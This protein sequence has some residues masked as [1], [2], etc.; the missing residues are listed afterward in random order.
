[1]NSASRYYANRYQDSVALMKLSAQVMAMPG[2]ELAAVVM[3]SA[4]NID[5]LAVEG[6]DTLDIKLRGGKNRVF[7]LLGDGELDE[8]SIWEACLVA[9]AYH[10]DNLVAVVDRNDFQANV[11]TEELIPLEPL[12]FKFQSFGWSCRTVDGHDFAALATAFENLPYAQGRPSVVIA[13]TVRGKGIPSIERRADRW[14]ADF[15]AAEVEA[16]LGELRG[17]AAATLE[18]EGLVVR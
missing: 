17:E 8:G 14:F 6:H 16:L 7:V 12:P 3:A 11:R 15:T 2:V 9:A 13:R 18:T 1:M 5:T 4:G 10:L